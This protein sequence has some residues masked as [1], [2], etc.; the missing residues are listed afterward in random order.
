LALAKVLSWRRAFEG[1][2]D[3]FDEVMRLHRQGLTGTSPW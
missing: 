2:A 1:L 3:S